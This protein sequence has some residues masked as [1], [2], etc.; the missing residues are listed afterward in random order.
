MW[1]LIV[2]NKHQITLELFEILS[3]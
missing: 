3:E 1:P 2:G